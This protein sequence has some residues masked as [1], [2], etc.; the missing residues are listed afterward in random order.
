M[1]ITNEFTVHTPIDRAWAAL[2]DLPGIAPCLPGAQLTGVDGDVYNGKVKVKVGPVISDFTGTARFTE[3]DDDSYRAVIDA[4]GRDSRAGGNAAALITAALTAEGDSTL[5]TVDT[6]LKISGKLAQFGSGM[7]KEISNKLLAQFVTNL[8]AKLATDDATDASPAPE[9][10]AAAPELRAAA[11]VVAASTPSAAAVGT[12]PE[13]GVAEA[14][15]VPAARPGPEAPSPATLT[16]NLI[17]A[18][19]GAAEPATPAVAGSDPLAAATTTAPSAVTAPPAAT[20]PPAPT[21]VAVAAG[22]P[23]ALDLLAVAGSS[24]YKRLL[25]LG[26]VVAV[27]VAVIAWLVGR[28]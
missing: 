28:R 16:A 22:E 8:E 21:K 12:A 3:K 1:K 27:I 6:D 17:P 18:D 26:V 23:E 19:P 9:S 10:S 5:V 20:T 15:G 14:P 2:T 24:V 11:P 4:K 13:T 7:I 25:P